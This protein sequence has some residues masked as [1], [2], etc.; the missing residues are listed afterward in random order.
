[1]NEEL[2]K[3]VDTAA[4]CEDQRRKTNGKVVRFICEKCLNEEPCFIET[5]GDPE[6]PFL[7]PWALASNDD[8]AAEWIELKEKTMKKTEKSKTEKFLI[9]GACANND[10]TCSKCGSCVSGSNFAHKL[11][12]GN[13]GGDVRAKC[14]CIS[15]S[16][17]FKWP[18][19][20]PQET[21]LIH[22]RLPLKQPAVKP[23]P[24]QH[25]RQDSIVSKQAVVID[26][27][28]S[29]HWKYMEKVLRTGADETRE[30]TFE[31]VMKIREWDYTSAAKHFY[32]HGFED[33][34][35][36]AAEMALNRIKEA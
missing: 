9:C 1:M 22:D 35:T 23:E 5:C 29:A 16:D 27:L 36:K 8:S 30:Y 32:G 33:G 13:C 10:E 6:P 18:N 26:E 31:D 34:Q 17:G 14:M 19:F 2:G 24:E 15:G 28:V 25:Y 4:E 3:W 11:G 12:D 7:C 21:R 20:T